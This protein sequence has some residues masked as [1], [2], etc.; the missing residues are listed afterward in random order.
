MQLRL[1]ASSQHLL[2]IF[3]ALLVL[4]MTGLIA[5]RTQRASQLEIKT[6]ATMAAPLA[7]GK[8]LPA[9]RVQHTATL[10]PNGKLLIAGGSGDGTDAGATNNAFLY[11]PKTGD[12]TET[13]AMKFARKGHFAVLLQ[14]GKV[15]VAGGKSGN[16]FL[17]T[18]ELY[19]PVSGAW[20]QTG[21][22]TKARHRAAATL[23]SYASSS[24]GTSRNG[25]ALAIGGESDG[26]AILNT[27]EVFNPSTGT[28][29]ATS[30]NLIRPRLAHSVTLLS[31]GEVM[32]AGGY[33]AANEPMT[34]VEIYDPLTDKWRLTNSLKTA[35]AGHSSTLLTNG[36]VIV[37]GGIGAGG[38]A[39]NTA[40]SFDAPNHT[41]TAESGK[42][43]GAR[44]FH[45]ASLLPNGTLFV[46]GG[47]SGAQGQATAR[48]ELYSPAT[49]Q[50]TSVGSFGE[51]RGFHTATILA[52]AMVVMVGG[53]PSL[54]LTSA[55]GSVEL[56]DPAVGKWLTQ[57]SSP[58]TLR[59]DH[60]ATLLT[61]GKVLIAGG[62]DSTGALKSAEIYDPAT[63][64]WA[65]TADMNIARGDHTATLLRSGKVLVTG[66]S[67][68]SGTLDTAEVYDPSTSSWSL[69]A[70]IMPNKRS[71][72]TATLMADGKVLA[73]GG[74]NT[75][76][77]NV[78]KG[79][80]IYD[81]ATNSWTTAGTLNTARRFHSATLLFDGRVLAA[82][83]DTAAALKTSELYDPATNKWTQQSSQMHVG[84]LRHTANLL[85]NGKVLVV[86]GLQS[87]TGS[88]SSFSGSA[89]LF[90]PSNQQWASVTAPAGR[91]GHTATLLAN[92]KVL[93]VGGYTIQASGAGNNSINDVD[94]TELYDPAKGASVPFS[95]TTKIT[96]PRDGHTATLL[97]SGKVLVV[98]GRAQTTDANGN[99][100]EVLVDRVELYDVGLDAVPTIAPAFVTTNWNG[101]GNPVCATGIRFQGGGE[102][103]GGNSTGSNANYPVVQLMR[104][105]NEQIYF[106]TPDPNSSQCSF[107]G[108]TNN[109]YA[110]LTVPAT[111][112][113]GTNN[114]LL[115][116]IAMM[117]VFV[118]GVPNTRAVIQ[119]PG[120]VRPG[121]STPLA[122][123]SGRVYTIADTGLQV[124]VELRSST[125]EVRNVVS[126]PN[127]EYIIED[128][129]TQ[130]A[131]TDTSG[132]IPSQ[133]AV[134]SPSQ[135]VTI[136]G[137]GFTV[138]SLVL[139]NGQQSQTTFV[140][141]TQLKANVP[142]SLLQSP[143]NIS[144]VVQ[145][146]GDTTAPEIIQVAAT[147]A[148][149][150]NI[151]NLNPSSTPAGSTPQPITINGT[152]L[153][154]GTT[155][156]LWNGQ[157]RDYNAAQS[158]AT[159][160]VF[161]PT[162][163]DLSQQTTVSI[164][165]INAG[166]T[167]N[168]V[169]FTITGAKTPVITSLEPSSATVGTAL[170]S[171]AV[172]GTNLINSNGTTDVLWNG[173]SRTILASQSTSS[174]LVFIPQSFDLSQAGTATVRV[175]HR[176]VTPN[177]E[178][179]T[180]SN[181]VNFPITPVPG[182]TISSLTPTSA[183]IP[184]ANSNSIA[185]QS[186][187]IIGT[188]FASNAVV[189]VN[190]K[191]L[192]TKFANS[193][194]LDAT[195]PGTLL[196]SQ[197]G[198]NF[199]VLN[200]TTNL[201][202]N[203][204]AFPINQT[205]PTTL[206]S[207]LAYPLFSSSCTVGTTVPVCS[208]NTTIT[209][210]NTNA[211]QSVRVRLFFIEG[212][213]GIATSSIQTINANQTL[214]MLASDVSPSKTGY[215]LAVAVNATNCPIVF[216]FL[217]GTEA[218]NGL[219]GYSGSVSAIPIR[220]I[221]APTGCGTGTAAT[222]L[223]F[224]GVMYDRI[225][226]QITADS[227]MTSSQ[228]GATL[229]VMNAVG[230]NLTSN[231]RASTVSSL[232]GAV[233]D[234]SL[235]SYSFTDSRTSSQ[236]I[237]ELN[238]RY[239][240]TSPRFDQ[241]L[242][243]GQIGKLTAFASP[244]L[245]GMTMTKTAAASSAALMRTVAFKIATLTI[246]VNNTF[247]I[248]F[249]D[250]PAETRTGEF[251]VPPSGGGLADLHTLQTK[252]ETI[253]PLPPEGGTTNTF[254]T[255]NPQLSLSQQQQPG[256]PITYTI[257]PSGNIPTGE[258]IEFLPVSRVVT[259]TGGGPVSF[260]AETAAPADVD[261]SFCG[262]TSA[263]LR[264][265]GGVTMP[266]GY[267]SEVVQVGL[268]LTN[269]KASGC[270]LPTDIT[271]NNT[272]G[273]Y[274]VD[275]A[276]LLPKVL[277]LEGSYQITPNDARFEF[278][279]QPSGMPEDPAGTVLA[280][281]VTGASIGW[282]F[283]A[284]AVNTCPASI[285]ATANGET[286][287]QICEGQPI[288]LDTPAVP[289]AT[290]YT[291]TLPNNS[292]IAGRNPTI[293]AATLANSG[294]YKVQVATP[295]CVMPVETTIQVTVNPSATANA[296]NDQTLCKATSGPTVFTLNGS[297][298]A[299]ASV[300]WSVINSTGDAA[301][302]IGNIGS[303]TSSVNVTGTGSVTLQLAAASPAGCGIAT[304][305]IVLNVT[306]SSV[307]INT[308]PTAQM[309]CLGG[310]ANFSVAATG[311]N[312]TYQWRK[313]SVNLSGQTAVTLSIPSVQLGDAGTYDVVINSSCGTLMSSAV[314][315]T[316]NSYEGDLSPNPNGDCQL[317]M[318]DWV[319]VGNIISGLVPG[320]SADELK[321]ADC[322]PRNTLGN[323]S[324][325]VAD[326]VQ[327]GRYAAALDPLVQVGG[328]SVSAFTVEMSA[329]E[330][331]KNLIKQSSTPSARTL[332]LRT[333]NLRSAN[334]TIEIELDARGEE[335]AVGFSLNLPAES[336]RLQSAT[337][338][339]ELGS[340]T[341]LINRSEVKA[342][343]I[344]F[345]V[346]MPIGQ[347]LP[348]GKLRIAT[349]RF[350]P[351]AAIKSSALGEFSFG[352]S[353]VSRELVNANAE[354]LPLNFARDDFAPLTV[355]SA[356]DFAQQKL[357]VE[358]IAV[359]FGENL[360]ATSANAG[361]LP[362]PNRI[363]DTQVVLTDSRG[364]EHFAPLFSCSSGQITFLVPPDV[365]LGFA[366]VAIR[367]RD[368]QLSTATVEIV[369]TAPAIFT[370]EFDQAPAAVLL[371]TQHDGSVS[372]ESL[373]QPDS[374]QQKFAIRNP[375]PAIPI[376]FG[377]SDQLIL[378]LFGTGL[379]NQ[380]GGTTA[381]LG[382]ATLPI[383]YVGAQ[384]EMTGLD[385]INVALPRW[386]VGSGEQ[387]LWLTVHGQSSD[388]IRLLIQ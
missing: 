314:A 214:T 34:T 41:W 250:P 10:L 361:S 300:V 121:G 90:D 115:P 132:V 248:L 239:P 305:Q 342:G 287:L 256:S 224:D 135:Q 359:A 293:A 143:G 322:A 178:V 334:H 326:W 28:W 265:A 56:H 330:F 237:N 47:F 268:H 48:A 65:P 169:P 337:V 261:A 349:L 112:L 133:L 23:L 379:R 316:V 167:S 60:T 213:T 386:L 119:A 321:R 163:A 378:V 350:S 102:A 53:A 295:T 192:V 207:V 83:G 182:P 331:T 141:P 320:L 282:N 55:L 31:N 204:V 355:V 332:R 71:D 172:N 62:R 288:N 108:W 25:F 126:G 164:Q 168:T 215:I 301:A 356:A 26:G 180:Y 238:S 11:D 105:D 365:T 267:T 175:L 97:P 4:L 177:G 252:R 77:T 157:R 209:L 44:A 37:V 218:V 194:R 220:G 340:A 154:N 348:V 189:R 5:T 6:V 131:D 346:S 179:L 240:L 219:S 92:G 339:D 12:W 353:P 217:R 374:P 109:S 357:A 123:L 140:S 136:N 308:Q 79:C 323:G 114:G 253:R 283:N 352:D 91:D 165:V 43:A 46:A 52:N 375:R 231:N 104:L 66:G 19:D 63:D 96:Y 368:N 244:A 324:L 70:N 354:S 87:T 116:G 7:T 285:T 294:T 225:P 13:G 262:R 103:A 33:S 184:L 145:T 30:T 373:K 206:G 311:Q 110:S 16:N 74:W 281:P 341:L 36:K 313:N 40:E 315:L 388:R 226:S 199:S 146:S 216:N 364:V 117:T 264:I 245:F 193:T 32:V 137:T 298:S 59:Y 269:A 291:W 21:S 222:T 232:T 80:D 73:V 85:P 17:T 387:S 39:L 377:E 255:R 243:A 327:A 196:A 186:V 195:V 328:P 257:T 54:P 82:G 113:P 382:D 208:S 86:S 290:S 181:V 151:T 383:L 147:S 101:S 205:T 363:N 279:Y 292:M 351:I 246:P 260:T 130:V 306:T 271:T 185:D 161:T 362:L 198:L 64:T 78:I 272:A 9:P 230:G 176:T 242:P 223:S 302:S 304:D 329:S 88:P 381:H 173:Q 221:T 142:S 15:L 228:S 150:P 159:K 107:K 81:P 20:T 380:R 310:T 49:G 58:N 284:Y 309:V 61:N 203:I 188:N 29:K 18:A 200:P 94:T 158:T 42:L 190:G 333:E 93:I 8:P 370:T 277:G 251:G 227:V 289:G 236:I 1:I 303:L 202:S 336:W 129:P 338:A 247:I 229:L 174:R 170:N 201:N 312:L 286:D 24:G 299:G 95:D 124:N 162:A 69:T 144:V 51:A 100:I 275:N 38:A 3:L 153:I 325:T 99:P 171:I 122:N 278:H 72:H 241:I 35:R 296:G 307:S 67:S 266:I 280:P 127:G 160:L 367:N 233:I 149:R 371:R 187:G 211:Q 139:L 45:S 57:S 384:N 125:G 148:S 317:T 50:W 345:I 259:L 249:N 98:G 358:S 106:L 235:N 134:G 258:A 120:A 75:T 155:Q 360:A 156:V 89:D 319:R 27:A 335:N 274:A 273:S 344:G 254:S 376:Q 297:A 2:R 111:T 128:L 22:L 212:L 210:T 166:G 14:S 118:N 369:E 276:V 197:T 270:S 343:R 76:G 183:T 385:Q 263:G 138:N 152:N 234:S 191:S 68:S 84:H 372:Y 318:A 347:K 366:T